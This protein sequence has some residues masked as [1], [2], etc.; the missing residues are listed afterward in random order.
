[1][2]IVFP[3]RQRWHVLSILLVS[4]S[5]SIWQT[6]V[7]TRS[8]ATEQIHERGSDILNSYE[9]LVRSE[10]AK[11]E[12]LPMILAI[13]KDI[14]RILSTSGD[15]GQIA[16]VNRYLEKINSIVQTSVIYVIDRTG[17]TIAASN[18]DEPIT[19][20]GVKLNYRPYFQTAIKGA[21]ARY[22]G[23]GTTSGERGYY[24]ASPVKQNG[25][26]LG[27]T[28]VKVD[29][30]RFETPGQWVG[31]KVAITDD[32]GVI[33]VS[34]D[35]TWQFKTIQPLDTQALKGIKE[36]RQYSD[37]VLSPLPVVEES[38]ADGQANVLTLREHPPDQLPY[39]NPSSKPVDREYLVQSS[40]MPDVGWKIHVFTD[41]APVRRAVVLAVAIAVL[42]LSVLFLMGL[43]LTQ[44]HR[45]IRAKLAA[46]E[47]LQ[48]AHDALETKVEERTAELRVSNDRLRRE[49]EERKRAE[50]ELVQ[51]G[52][53]AALGQLSAGIVHEVNQPLAAIQSYAGNALVFLER[54]RYNQAKSNLVTIGELTGRIAEITTHLKTFARKSPGK[55]K[56]VSLKGVI[57]YS[58]S[59]VESQTKRD[60]VDVIQ[61]VPDSDVFVRGDSI[62]LEQVMVN[63][64][65]NA[66]EAMHG[67]VRPKKIIIEIEESAEKVLLSIRDTGPGIAED[68]LPQIFDAFFTTKEVGEGLGLGLSL[69][70]KILREFGGSMRVANHESG[71]AV[72]T[73]TLLQAAAVPKRVV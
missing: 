38:H 41:M 69:S 5:L 9:T 56:P 35:P 40:E 43:Y 7:W 17:L 30:G 23:M 45:A 11:Y 68:D 25:E 61:A 58:L 51:A 28:V 46:Q 47:A 22:F 2:K 71:G 26:I 55:V 3:K 63:L 15:E 6:A 59:L 34:S 18:W 36:S 52:K 4:I 66:L 8:V 24:F 72:F 53:L 49:I 20:V 48:E 37:V 67:Q 14:I 70:N 29:V 33:F 13:K 19:F 1:M 62:R 73:I 44:R 31:S 12:F 32:H 27:V 39:E 64:L 65:K 60:A 10:L 54:E 16:S 21:I 50:N 42:C 57:A